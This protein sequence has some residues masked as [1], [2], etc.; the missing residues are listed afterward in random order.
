[1]VVMSPDKYTKVNLTNDVP[2]AYYHIN[3]TILIMPKRGGHLGGSI[4]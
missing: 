1:M 2:E 3:T 4:G